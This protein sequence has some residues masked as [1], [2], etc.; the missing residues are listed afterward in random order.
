M[1]S[2][3]VKIADID[4]YITPSQNCIKPIQEGTG[5]I[6][7]DMNEKKLVLEKPDLIKTDKNNAAKVSLTDCLACSGCVTTAET[8]LIQAQSIDEFLRNVKLEDRVSI[9]CIS[10]QS[11]LSLAYYFNIDHI[12]AMDRLCK[13]LYIA[14]VKYVISYDAAVSLSLELSYEEWKNKNKNFILCSECPGWVCYAEKK[15]G[16]WVIPYM[17]KVKSPQQILGHAIKTLFKNKF[18]KNVYLSCIMPCFDKKLEASRESHKTE[19]MQLE[20]DTVIST[21]EIIELLQK[22]EI[23]FI[24]ENAFDF[25]IDIYFTFDDL[26]N[27]TKP[28]QNYSIFFASK[29]NFSSNAYSEFIINRYIEENNLKDK[30]VI[31]R[32]TLKNVDMREIS[33]I[34]DGKTLLSFCLVYGF[35]N[36]QNILRT[37]T[38][39]K[40]SFIEIMA[41][42]GGCI[43]GGGQMKPRDP[44]QTPRDVLKSIE[45]N[46]LEYNYDRDISKELET[47]RKLLN[48]SNV[49]TE[50]KALEN[51]GVSLKW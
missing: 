24:A 43:N 33:L 2:G 21:N 51:T 45:D 7:F 39:I 16:E 3:I 6:K 18:N 22:M 50:Y 32:K 14:G 27:D 26:V 37:K 17:S 1:F 9:V 40:Y 28:I 42:P 23:N 13:V 10:P 34:Q 15:I 4:D 25:K 35:R 29:I 11:V 5:K 20:V 49:Y 48:D 36:I 30:A 12:S 44:N 19:D 38:K 46:L 41:C 31:E 47:L 8:L